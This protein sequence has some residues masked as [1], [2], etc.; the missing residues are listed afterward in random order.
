MSPLSL[1]Q[2]AAAAT[3][4]PAASS[5]LLLLAACGPDAVAWLPDAPALVV[6]AETL[7]FPDVPVG[8]AATA[9]VVVRNDGEAPGTYALTTDGPFSVDRAELELGIAGEAR[10][11]L[12][13]RPETWADAAGAL[14]IDG[15]ARVRLLGPVRT[16]VDGD[17]VDGAASGGAD[18]DD[19]DPAVY[20]GAD[21]PCG[22]DRDAD[23]DPVGDDDCDGDGTAADDDCDDADASVYPGAAE[24][25]P[26]DR[27]DDCDGRIDEDFVA[28]DALVITEISPRAPSWLELCNHAEQP[29]H[30]DNFTITTTAGTISL[31]AGRID[32]GA[33]AAICAS[34]ITDCAFHASIVIAAADTVTLSVEDR[35]LDTVAADAS[36]GWDAAWAWAL[37]PA[38]ATSAGNDAADA[39]C[40]ADG[41]AGRPNDACVPAGGAR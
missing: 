20:P 41:S 32:A 11:T 12:Q 18:C 27:D 24:A 1:A 36:W 34:R 10:L 2:R 4:M 30:A 13:F 35:V 9:A 28:L 6:G 21:D 39:W 8:A 22:D 7:T 31:P 40:R 38:R 25:G 5:L 26:N 23:C 29:I 15:V 33:C 19:A 37:D 16:D 14:N 3:A 17:G